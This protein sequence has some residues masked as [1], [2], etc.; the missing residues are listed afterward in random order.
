MCKGDLSLIRA[1][2]AVDTLI[3]IDCWLK[4]RLKFRYKFD[5]NWKVYTKSLIQV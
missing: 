4:W 2:Y 3:H 5:K 1:A